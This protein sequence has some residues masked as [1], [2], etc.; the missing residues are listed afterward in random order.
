VTP[1]SFVFRYY[2]RMTPSAET[3]IDNLRLL[4][5]A[6]AESPLA[7]RYQLV[8][9]LL[10][11]MAREGRPLAHDPDADF[12][13]LE[14]HQAEME[15]AIPVLVNAGFRKWRRY[16]ANDG[17][18]RV[19]AF[20]KDEMRFEFFCTRPTGAGILSYYIFVGGRSPEQIEKS[21]PD[22]ALVRQEFL[23]RAWRVP[24][25]VDAALTYHYGDWRT[26]D[27]SWDCADDRNVIRREEWM[28]K[29]RR[30]WRHPWSPRVLEKRLEHVLRQRRRRGRSL[31]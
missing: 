11:G 8:G 21:Y 16:V 10:L 26:P 30:E 2:V 4:N 1:A 31:P 29:W 22:M 28:N 6:L 25:D 5:D 12:F 17:R 15:A 24:C 23:G 14:K 19:Y 27:E 7:D 3:F 18:V 9:G 20:Q 13:F